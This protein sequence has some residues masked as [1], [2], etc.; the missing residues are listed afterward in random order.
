MTATQPAGYRE[1]LLSELEAVIASTRQA[2]SGAGT[3]VLDQASVGRVS[4]MD[5]MQQQAMAKGVVERLLIRR[6]KLEAALERLDNG[7]YGICCQCEM[8]VE[9]ERLEH[10]PAAVFCSE[11][12]AARE[13]SKGERK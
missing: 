5:A 1:R 10:D 4:R 7:G 9:P 13:A 12:A 2:E 3:V 11:C 6:R 8:L